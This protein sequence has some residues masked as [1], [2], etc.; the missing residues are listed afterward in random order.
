MSRVARFFFVQHTKTGK[1]IPKT[2]KIYPI[3][4]K[5]TKWQYN[6]PSS[7][8]ARP[9]RNYPNRATL[10]CSVNP[11]DVYRALYYLTLISLIARKEDMT[12]VTYICR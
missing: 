6:L 1:N 9:S 5:Y 11:V 10:M 8:F 4:I 12:I 2:H 7:F 3:S